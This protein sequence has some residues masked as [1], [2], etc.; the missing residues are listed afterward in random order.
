MT[1]DSILESLSSLPSAWREQ[2]ADVLCKIEKDKEASDCEE[3]KECES[4]TS[5]SEF[6]IDGTEVSITYTDENGTTYDRSFNF[7]AMLNALLDDIDPACV[8]TPTEWANM[9]WIERME[10]IVAYTDNCCSTT[11]TTTIA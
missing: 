1:K 7:S 11:T 5:L 9:T 10:T 8:A 2:I 3:V 4:N 6:I